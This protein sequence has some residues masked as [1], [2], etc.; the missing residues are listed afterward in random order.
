M[1]L[2]FRWRAAI[3]LAAA[4]A[5]T[6]SAQ[7]PPA[8]PAGVEFFEK[9]IRPLLAAN[10]YQCHGPEKKRAGLTLG[11]LEGILKG[12][13]RGPAITPGNPDQSLLIRAV[14]YDGDPRMPPKGRLS[15][16]QIA[17]LVAW[18]KMGAPGP[19]VEHVLAATK[20]GE[21][22][23]AERRKHWAYQPVVAVTLPKVKNAS[24]CT[25]PIDFFILDRIEKAGLSP[26]PSADRR[27]LIRRVTFDLIGL[28]P[29]PAEVDAFL[30][31][32]SPK[33]FEK[34][35]DRLLAS[36]HYGERWA[37]HWLDLVRYSETLGFEFDYD[38]FNA[39]R[40]RDYVIRAF[41]ADLPYDQFIVEHLA[42][43]LLPTPRRHEVEGFN[44]SILATGFFWMGEAKQTPVD[45]RQEQADVIDNQIDVL[46]KALLAQTVACARCHDHKFDAV[47]TRDYYALAGYLKSSRY[48]QASIDPPERITAKAEEIA[49]LKAQIRALAASEWVRMGLGQI[50]KAAAYLLAARKVMDARGLGAKERESVLEEAAREFDLNSARLRR[51]L[52]ALKQAD[53]SS[54]P[55]H[56]W[57]RM[58][59]KGTGGAEPFQKR[60]LTLD[61]AL[62]EQE[63]KA[64]GASAERFEDFRRTTFEG[65]YVTGDAFG[66][67]PAQ[68][69]D[70]VVGDRPDRPIAEFVAGG[71]H[72]GLLSNRLQ[73]ELR[74]RTF[75]IDKR[76]VHFRLTGRAA[77]V[78]L[79]IDGYTLIMN[80]I[81][82]KLTIALPTVPE[83]KEDGRLV[84][85]T[86]PV[87]RWVGHRAFIEVLDNNIPVQRLNPPPSTGKVP[88]G[89]DGY[90]VVDQVLFSNDPDPPP[91]A[92]NRI[93]LK[94]LALARGDGLEAL[95]AAYQELM[96]EE[97]RHWRAG[98]T[99]RTPAGED[100]IA[101]LNWLL[102]NGLLDGLPDRE[103]AH[104]AELLTKYRRIEAALPLPTRAP[105]MA[106]GTG[107]DEFVSLRGNYKT[108][109]ERAPRRPPEV[110]AG[111][112]GHHGAPGR[113]SQA[114]RAIYSS[115][116]SGR[117]DLARRLADPSNPLTSRVLMNRL[118]QHH[119]GEGI[120]R[121]PDD[122]GRMG[123]PPTHPEL[124]DYLAAE[125]V[126]H[127]WSIKH[128]H[129]MMVLSSTY[130]MSSQPDPGQA[131][132]DPENR[133]WHRMSVQRLEAEAIRDA[134]LA[135][136]GRLNR[137]MYGPSVLP[138]LTN[139]ME[140]RG[141]PK[142]GPLDGDGRRSIYLNVRR[143]FLTPMLVAFDYPASFDTMG[144][145]GVSS[146][147]A[148]ALTLMNDPF[149]VEQ[150][151][152]WAKR[153][154]ADPGQSAGQRVDALYR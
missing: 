94:A 95:A 121:T 144:R 126:G 75:T 63:A 106:D 27:A 10:C 114:E 124:L 34:I 29:T 141:R 123:Q 39:W 77:R 140:G 15:E 65:W 66:P 133:L 24:W 108:P 111:V 91:A 23:L 30:A 101:L 53:T 26:A 134:I 88:E 25:S 147:P 139:Y 116:G 118:W 127:G 129:R 135:V 130:Q 41:N 78:N 109:G 31:D 12:G 48:Q 96:V 20:K 1:V 112:S 9:R 60:R 45:I 153:A 67:G 120:V 105:A 76:Y 100:G 44:E 54:H 87:D 47:S 21:F 13:D 122:F 50:G 136:S 61:A 46:S 40:Y 150:A 131:K 73:G 83:D 2:S 115:G 137:T 154:L 43:D 151:A 102:Q 51:W 22:D 3:L 148:Q 85:R 74:S 62:A 117:L 19:K 5:I 69:G 52:A 93:N 14:Y 71:A 99:K 16:E 113:L 42:G 92:P 6:V 49:A 38:L 80:P 8:S 132:L 97:L 57:L 28:P 81:Y 86:M 110:L 72:S 107:E 68:A 104:L 90:V 18:V 36:P 55:L 143:N 79:V 17:D 145:R 146:A 138:H 128:M 82:G 7:Q 149:V 64:A 4:S 103:P 142:S 84:W 152:L 89:D 70:F 11:T 56:A 59:G 32:N 119:F 58:V 35:V 33:A 98:K 125:F 37:R